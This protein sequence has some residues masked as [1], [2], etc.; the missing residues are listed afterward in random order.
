MFLYITEE[1]LKR[2]WNL[3]LAERVEKCVQKRCPRDMTFLEKPK[4]CG[5]LC[6]KGLHSI[7]ETTP[8]IYKGKIFV[9]SLVTEVGF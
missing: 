5:A 3:T 6:L 8:E 9:F 4:G 1:K 7:K 2:L